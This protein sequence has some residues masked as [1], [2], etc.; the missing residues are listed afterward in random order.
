MAVFLSTT[1][2]LLLGVQGACCLWT[3]S[4]ITAKSGGSVTIPCHYHRIHKDLQKYWCKGKNWSTCMTMQPTNPKEKR[5]GISF[6]NIPDELLTTMTLTNLRSSD[7]NRYWCAAKIGGP[8][9]RD[10]KTVLELTVTEGIPDLSVA[11]NMVSGQENGNVT[12]QCLYS[13]TLKDTEKKWC[14]SGQ[15]HSCQSAQDIELSP[16]AAVQINDT[17][18]GV[19]TVIL[20]GLKRTYS[21]L[22]TFTMVPQLTYNPS[23]SAV[24]STTQSSPPYSDVHSHNSVATFSSTTSELPGSTSFQT[25]KTGQ[26]STASPKQLSKIQ[27]STYSTT[28]AN[29]KEDSSNSSSSKRTQVTR[30]SA[31]TSVGSDS[32]MTVPSKYLTFGPKS[33]FECRNLV[34]V[35]ALVC[36]GLLLFIFAGLL[37]ILIKWKQDTNTREE[38]TEITTQFLANDRDDLLENEWTSTSIVQFSTDSNSITIT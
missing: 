10:I 7:S 31:T 20:T 30:G 5:T 38:A 9:Q 26:I 32:A 1:L 34:W 8:L 2:V 19:F 4:K 27:S 25:D 28:M 24:H 14:K 3:V 13:E 36:G 15:L 16:D 18:D 12:V 11:S 37:W 21:G 22:S 35:L 23:N 33:T 17:N 29:T 6:L